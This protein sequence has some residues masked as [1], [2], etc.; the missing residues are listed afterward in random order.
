MILLQIPAATAATPL[1]SLSAV[2]LDTE[3]T[4]LDV[5]KAR[6]LEIGAVAL[7][8]GVVEEE[9]RF[10]EYVG[11]DEVISPES[12]AVH[13][14]TK[15]TIAGKESFAEVYGRFRRFA[16]GHVV[17]G[18]SFDFDLTMLRKEHERAGLSWKP[19][20]ALDVKQLIRLARLPLPN[21]S[22][23]TVASWFSIEVKDR[24]TAF[25]DAVL[26]A[27][28]YLA[29]L[30]ILRERGIRTL[31]EAMAACRKL[32]GDAAVPGK[33]LD[34]IH[35]GVS[36]ASSMSV[37][38][39]ADSYPYRHR[40]ADVMASPPLTISSRADLRTAL[41]MLAE[42]RVSSLFVE[43]SDGGPHGIITERDVLRAIARDGEKAL[44]KPLLTNASFPLLTL[45][46]SDFIYVAIGRMRQHKV[47]HLGVVNEENNLVGALS[48]RD[49]LKARAEE[50]LA[51]TQALSDA[52]SIGELA[53]VWKKLAAAA[54]ALVAE[55]VDPRDIAAIVS[56]EVCALT[57]R[58]ARMAEIAMTVSTKK[59]DDLSFAVFVLGSGGRGESLLA[60][61]QDNAII[62][63]A[64]DEA[65]AQEW[66]K[67]MATRMNAILD[68]IG[69]PLCKG[70]VMAR[71]DA[72]RQ[73][74]ASWRK[75]VSSWL[76]KSN[77]QDIM[78]ADIFF[79]AVPVYGDAA[80]AEDLRAD[81]IAAASKTETFLKLM[82]LSA[83][84]ASP[85]LGWFGRFSTDEG[86]RMDLKK[87]GIM[88]IFSA[89][90]VLAL[91]YRIF[92]RSTRERFGALR[93]NPAVPQRTLETLGEAHGILLAA[94][95]R[96]QLEDIEKG[97]PPS[98]RVDPAILSALEKDR[99][100]WALEQVKSVGDVLGDPIA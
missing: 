22:L 97:I 51:L 23:E 66:L 21:D 50:A 20:R 83:A 6:I 5:R 25:G 72:W 3:T 94:I 81:A 41:K 1:V 47:R 57:A 92:A 96:Q 38:A 34:S 33:Q 4:S 27:R 9:R 17:L 24:H 91:R 69:V 13:G 73:S 80:L 76:S 31:G 30:P 95:L 77:P 39:R 89:A 16:A 19:P 82:S 85:P 42:K 74:T 49:L 54:N 58:A 79:D 70:G 71:N 7:T 43:P 59:P 8:H 26:T 90:R 67:A 87:G 64:P 35:E 63:E 56:G 12:T 36:P 15:E 46:A 11:V 28:I 78:N 44:A 14:I 86:G 84:N 60:L 32:D 52:A 29:L 40:V 62:F 98:N 65:E 37:L 2:V 10:S 53:E 68:E 99:L 45:K 100:K 61:D 88:P 48:Q 75:Q 55:D 18:Y 93:G